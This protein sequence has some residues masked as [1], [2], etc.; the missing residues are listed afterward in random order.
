MKKLEMEPN[1][2]ETEFTK[3]T[4]GINL[5]AKEW[6]LN[7]VES[8]D[9]ILEIGC[10][11]GILA[12]KLAQKSSKVI[13]ID[14]NHSMINE[15]KT[16]LPDE[17]Q[18]KVS[19]F[20]G[21][22]VSFDQS[23]PDKNIVFD[24]I[25]S[26]FMLSELRPL[27]QQI[28]LRE[29]WKKLKPEGKLIIAA[30]FEPSGISK[31]PFLIKRWWYKKKLRKIS[32]GITNPLRWFHKYPEA[33]GYKLI[34]NKWWEH[35]SIQALEYQKIV[36]NIENLNQQQAEPGYYKPELKS[37]NGIGAF[38]RK[39]RCIFTGQIDHVPIEPGIY[40]SGTPGPKDPII[41][42]ANYDYTY[43]RVMNDLKK[44]NAFVL[45]VD[46]RGINVWCAAR[47]DDFG[48]K[49]LMEAVDATGIQHITKTKRLFLPQLCAGGV[50]APKLPMKT[51]K[52]PFDIMYGPVWSKDLPEYLDTKPVRKPIKMKSAEFT[53][54]HRILAGTTHTA[55][56]FRKI[57]LIPLLAFL[58]ILLIAK[59][60]SV[61]WV[62]LNYV[63]SI[64]LTNLLIAGAI[65][66]TNFTR[67]FIKKATV[68]G[69]GNMIFLGI[70]SYLIH[71]SWIFTLFNLLMYFWLGF[72]TT[73]SFSGYT[74]ATSPREIG[75]EYPKFQKINKL[76]L[77]FAI[78]LS[79]SAL[80]ILI[81]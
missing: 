26:T 8:D 10:G 38:F 7:K 23:I 80:I 3:L 16:N 40:I 74:F 12:K 46:S 48:N 36:P 52:F 59:Q 70:I 71:S 35:G 11:P 29:A 54:P 58:G 28:F 47:G 14:Q 24:K 37:F 6:I 34:D 69:M 20:T 45:C 57:F 5:E 76:L 43:I 39:I 51:P 81:I 60:T 50:S 78:G 67:K 27:E 63:M 61:I 75:E 4:K 30:E 9:T 19:F 56:L 1:S 44:T 53:L 49:Q 62:V 68:L 13:A 41:V 21:N 18:N 65:P 66:L 79:I 22:A 33:I 32:S 31:L 55:F 17:I 73:M 42:T 77:I 25:I 2:Y 15:A 64:I 72:F